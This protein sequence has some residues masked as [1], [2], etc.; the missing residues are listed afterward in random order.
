MLLVCVIGLGSHRAAAGDAPCADVQQIAELL[1]N[2]VLAV[3][4]SVTPE[5]LAQSW[6]GG[7]KRTGWGSSTTWAQVQDK[8]AVY[9]TFVPAETGPGFRLRAIRIRREGSESRVREDA[10]RL[11]LVF[12]PELTTQEERELRRLANVVTSWRIPA[13]LDVPGTRSMRSIS[14]SEIPRQNKSEQQRWQVEVTYNRFDD[15]PVKLGDFW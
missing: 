4:S 2:Q 13:A 15:P 1:R 12:G 6:P 5:R 7:L 11:A 10:N 9:F 14:I 8:C 3:W